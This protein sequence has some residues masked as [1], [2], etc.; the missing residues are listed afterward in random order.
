MY[1]SYH[2]KAKKL[3]KDGELIDY[4]IVDEYNGISPAL[5]LFFKT[6]KPMPVRKPMWECYFKIINEFYKK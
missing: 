2:N 4:K 1:F 3:I 5:V 6:H